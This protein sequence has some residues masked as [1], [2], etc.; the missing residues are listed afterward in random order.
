METI[1]SALAAAYRKDFGNKVQNIEVEYDVESGKIKA[2]DVKTVVPD[3]E[4]ENVEKAEEERRAKQEA[5][6]VKMKELIENGKEIPEEMKEP[7][8]NEGPT[9]NEKS[10]IMLK[11]AKKVDSDAKI[12]VVLRMELIVPGEF[13]RMAA[14][15]AKQV[16]MQKLREAERE[17][18]FGEFK[19]FEHTCVM[20]TVQRREGKSVLIDL[21][22]ATGMMRPEDQVP[23]ERY[24]TGSRMKFFI[25]SVA[26]TSRGPEILLSRTDAE[27]VRSLF[28]TEIPEVAESIVLIKGVAREPGSRTKVAVYTEDDSIDPI[29]ACIGQRGTRIQTII[30]EMGGEKIDIVQWSDDINELIA[31]ALSPAKV[32][33]VEITKGEE[34]EDIA[35]VTVPEDQ[36]SL[37]VGRGGQNVRLASRMAGMRINVQGPQGEEIETK[38]GS[39]DVEK[40]EDDTEDEVVSSEEVVEE[41]V[42][43]DAE[44]VSEETVSE[45]P[46]EIKEK[47]TKEE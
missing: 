29:G 37:A 19:E 35:V 28:E 12:D 38:E 24:N 33:G 10:E 4:L 21:G 16:V 8:V 18:V 26:L 23:T 15:T 32:S 44:E 41:T 40:I 46:E 34:D 43:D 1:E 22:R 14:M 31:N 2:F 39:D 30:A 7:I 20:G 17:V 47:D 13:G 25:R 6:N 42:K 11:D 45:E 36:L 27:L 9:F 5:R 3:V